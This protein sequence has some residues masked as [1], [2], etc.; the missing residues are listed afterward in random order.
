MT[1]E[2]K[3]ISPQLSQLVLKEL[4]KAVSTFNGDDIYFFK[5]AI[6]ILFADL[7]TEIGEKRLKEEW[8]DLGY[9]WKKTMDNLIKIEGKALKIKA[10]YD[11]IQDKSFRKKDKE[12]KIKKYY[13]KVASKMP[14]ILPDFFCFLIFLIKKS[15]INRMTIPS[16][17]FKIISHNK[18]LKPSPTI[19]GGISKESD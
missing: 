12:E 5:R 16:S 2:I 13:Q 10:Y 17:Y 11:S 8:D 9:N 3:S 19:F 15:Q 7:K 6:D 4:G 14:I 18:M 1:E